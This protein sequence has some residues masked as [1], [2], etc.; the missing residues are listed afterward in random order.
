[1]KFFII[2]NRKWMFLVAL[3]TLFSCDKTFT[4]HR[5]IKNNSNDT[6]KVIN[7]DFDSTYFIMP[8]NE[9]MIYGFK[10]LDR[11]QESE[12]CKWLGD[13][14]IIK[15]IH[16]TVCQKATSIEANWVSSITPT[17]DGKIQ[18]C[19]FSVENSDF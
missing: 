9:K 16:D 1:M 7:P 11:N 8:G 2:L 19:T 10:S 5:F 12:P 18:K 17:E 3:V 13:T 4:H 6:L 14:L 15:T